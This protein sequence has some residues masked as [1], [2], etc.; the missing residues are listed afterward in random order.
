VLVLSF[1]LGQAML[2]GVLE[3]ILRLMREKRWTPQTSDP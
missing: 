2:A 3:E 1:E